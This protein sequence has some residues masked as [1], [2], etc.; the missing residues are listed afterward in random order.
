MSL[1]RV[2][3]EQ[4]VLAI[5]ISIV[6]VVVGALAL[7]T[8]RSRSIRTCPPTVVVSTTYPGL[9]PKRYLKHRS[10]ADRAGS[11]RC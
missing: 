1:G 10:H 4:P 11:E 3:V 2:A 9:Q 6:I 5:V 7:L 8:S